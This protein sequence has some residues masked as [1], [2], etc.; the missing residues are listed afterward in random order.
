[1]DFASADRRCDRAVA[2]VYAERY[3]VFW[4]ERRVASSASRT[5]SA[6]AVRAGGKHKCDKCGCPKSCHFK[7]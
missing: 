1:M 3:G 2:A 6:C 4:Q 5:A 7:P